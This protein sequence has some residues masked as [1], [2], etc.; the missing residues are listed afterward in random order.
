MTI[1]CQHQCRERWAGATACLA[2]RRAVTLYKLLQ[3]NAAL[4]GQSKYLVIYKPCPRFA[5][6]Y[7]WPEFSSYGASNRTRP[8]RLSMPSTPATPRNPASPPACCCGAHARRT[9]RPG[10]A[11]APAAG[12][13]QPS[14]A[15]LAQTGPLHSSRRWQGD[16]RRLLVAIPLTTRSL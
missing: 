10:P 12:P 7:F 2:P 5:L 14:P 9:L 3:R 6:V 4:R 8:S 11:R 16:P 1:D 13:C 15:P